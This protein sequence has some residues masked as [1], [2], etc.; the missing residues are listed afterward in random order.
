MLGFGEIVCFYSIQ[1]S[2]PASHQ[3][4]GLEVLCPTQDTL[5]LLQL[6]TSALIREVD[7]KNPVA[8]VY[9]N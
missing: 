9:H 2:L 4:P 6:G 7:Q 8:V 5:E 3:L 1:R